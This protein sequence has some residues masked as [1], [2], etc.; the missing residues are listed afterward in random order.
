[1]DERIRTADDGTVNLLGARCRACGH[2]FFPRAEV[3]PYSGDDDV[4]DV[5]LAP[6]GTLWGWTAV[7]ASPPGYSGPLPYGMGIVELDGGLRV[8]GRLTVA[9]P[10]ELS[11]GQPMTTVSVDLEIEPATDPGSDTEPQ[12]LT[13][14]AFAPREPVR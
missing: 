2:Y 9:D 8:L 6:N 12:S 5:D 13:V 7:T 4:E 14:W 3:C 1:M 11:F 10:A